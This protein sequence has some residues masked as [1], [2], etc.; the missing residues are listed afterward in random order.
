MSISE[1]DLVFYYSKGP[2]GQSQSGASASIGGEIASQITTDKL[3]DNVTK[4]QTQK[5]L[6]DYR[7]IYLKNTNSTE[8]LTNLNLSITEY[9]PSTIEYGF[10]GVS[11]VTITGL[12][13]NVTSNGT[14]V[15]YTYKTTSTPIVEGQNVIVTNILPSSYKYSGIVVSATVDPIGTVD[16]YKIHQFSVESTA[17]DSYQTGGTVSQK[18]IVNPPDIQTITFNYSS[19]P[20]EDS[21]NTFDITYESETQTVLWKSDPNEQAV[22]IQNK[23]KNILRLYNTT[24]SLVSSVSESETFKVVMY[25]Q[26][27]GDNKLLISLSPQLSSSVTSVVNRTQNGGPINK[28]TTAIPSK[29]TAPKISFLPPDRVYVINNFYPE[30]VIGIWIKRT[31]SANTLASDND[32]FSIDLSA[33]GNTITI[34]PTPTP[35]STPEVTPGPTATIGPTATVG[36]TPTKTPTAT[37]TVTPTVTP[38]GFTFPPTAT[39]TPT[40][41]P[42]TTGGNDILITGIDSDTPVVVEV[43]NTAVTWTAVDS[44]TKIKFKTYPSDFGDNIT[45]KN[46]IVNLKVGGGTFTQIASFDAPNGIVGRSYT[47]YTKCSSIGALCCVKGTKDYNLIETSGIFPDLS[48]TINITVSNTGC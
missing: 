23:L 1:S 19:K 36:I 16:N 7:C 39:A 14:I 18:G 29:I 9:L 24:V 11:L 34:T 37:P 27:Y 48:N 45:P 17:T 30:D 38:P 47:I 3:F 8:A 12:I 2:E 40:I 22:E 4:E 35:T 15:T 33:E 42:T 28:T 21:N 13:T 26:R 5:G 32:G 46:Y 20:G 44:N 31:V 6:I 10:E 41:T 25:N 43:G